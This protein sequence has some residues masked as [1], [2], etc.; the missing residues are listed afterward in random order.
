MSLT[1]AALLAAT[2]TVT[3]VCSWDHPGHRPFMGDVVAAVDR[4]QDIPAEVRGKLKARMARRAYDEIVAIRRDTIVGAATYA[5]EIRDMHFGNGQVC[6]TV[7]RSK[8][9]DAMQ[10]RGLVYCESGHCILVPTVCRNVSRIV[11]RSPAIS[12]AQGEAPAAPAPRTAIIPDR[13]VVQDAVPI[14]PAPAPTATPVTP[15]TSFVA[16][17]APEAPVNPLSTTEVPVVPPE[18]TYLVP[19]VTAL[20]TANGLNDPT[21]NNPSPV[22]EPGTWAMFL[23][24]LLWVVRRARRR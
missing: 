12:A 10:E 11:R 16:Q 23:A 21:P 2:S 4:Y 24:G 9:T 3:P 15:P 22:P 18:V 17:A 8:W 6:G 20:P 19:V 5:P 14:P 13:G 1:L 7:T